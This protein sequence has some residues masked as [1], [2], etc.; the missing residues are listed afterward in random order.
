MKIFHAHLEQLRKDEMSEFMD[1]DQYP[2]TTMNDTRVSMQLLVYLLRLSNSI[3]GVHVRSGRKINNVA[4]DYFPRFLPPPMVGSQNIF[5]CNKRI[6]FVV[7]HCF[8]DN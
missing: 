6:R 3:T 5:Y 4:L 2:R 7:V 8:C 1:E